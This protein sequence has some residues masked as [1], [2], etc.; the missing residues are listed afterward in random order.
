MQATSTAKTSE[1]ASLQ[2]KSTAKTSEHLA[3]L[4]KL[5]KRN[6]LDAEYHEQEMG[7]QR[8]RI[9]LLNRTHRDQKARLEAEKLALSLRL[10]ASEHSDSETDLPDLVSLVVNCL[11]S[12]AD[13]YLLQDE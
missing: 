5:I 7:F 11:C 6:R 2:A 3:Q 4:S 12:M 1:I 8:E 9:D 10:G 13:V